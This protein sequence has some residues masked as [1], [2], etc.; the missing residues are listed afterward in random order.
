MIHSG[1]RKIILAASKLEKWKQV[2]L[3]DRVLGQRYGSGGPNK[4]D[5]T[6]CAQNQMEKVMKKSK[7]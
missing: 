4:S 6:T 7:T 2:V 3:R 5:L 1:F